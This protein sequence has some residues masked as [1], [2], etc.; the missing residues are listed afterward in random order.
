MCRG[1]APC[2]PGRRRCPPGT[3]TGL[4]RLRQALQH[5]TRSPGSC[6]RST[7][8]RSL[9]ARLGQSRSSIGTLSHVVDSGRRGVSAAQ[10]ACCRAQLLRRRWPRGGLGEGRVCAW[11]DNESASDTS[12]QARTISHACVTLAVDPLRAGGRGSLGCESWRWAAGVGGASLSS[13]RDNT[14]C[15]AG[16]LQSSV[17]K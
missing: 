14:G 1:G 11:V 13:C 9:R 16:A 17:E 8:A 4:C 12:E 5:S 6:S 2:C 3:C 7:V 10:E 15:D